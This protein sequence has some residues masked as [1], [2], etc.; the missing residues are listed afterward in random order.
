MSEVYEHI[1]FRGR[2]LVDLQ[3]LPNP[4]VGSD[5]SIISAELEVCF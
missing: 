4:E 1:A 3:L 5:P 2:E